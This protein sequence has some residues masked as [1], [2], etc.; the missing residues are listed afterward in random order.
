MGLRQKE[1]LIILRKESLFGTEQRPVG[2]LGPSKDGPVYKGGGNTGPALYI[3][4][5]LDGDGDS[6]FY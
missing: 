2:P 5:S 3:G 4:F 1:G 6:I